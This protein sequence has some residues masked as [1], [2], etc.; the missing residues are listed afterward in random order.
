MCYM[1]QAIHQQ[2]PRPNPIKY[3]DSIQF[4]QFGC[5]IGV[6][7]IE[8]PVPWCEIIHKQQYAIG[9]CILYIFAD[10]YLRQ[11]YIST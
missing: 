6:G 7:L 11:L 1:N 9:S 2:N 3:S 8:G 10:Q 5:L 4:I